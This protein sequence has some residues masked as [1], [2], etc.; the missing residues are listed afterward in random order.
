MSRKAYSTDNAPPEG[1][2]GRPR[3]ELLDAR[4]WLSATIDQFIVVLDASIR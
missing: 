2:F 4:E 1:F 3:N